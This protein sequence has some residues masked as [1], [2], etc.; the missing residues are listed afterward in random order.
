MNKSFLVTAALIVLVCPLFARAD[1]LPPKTNVWDP[2][3]LGGPLVVCTGTATPART[4]QNGTVIPAIPA[5][6]N[7]CDVVAQTANVI[8]FAIA[9]VIWIIVPILVAV[10]GIMVMLGG[11][12]PDLIERAKKTI[13]GAVWGLVIVLCAWLAVYSVVGSFGKLNQFVG[14]FPGGPAACR[15]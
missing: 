14:G 3:I 4:L 7:L 11:P 5:C 13:T 15:I 1:S 8:Y 10:G 9:V 12:N 2:R 6:N